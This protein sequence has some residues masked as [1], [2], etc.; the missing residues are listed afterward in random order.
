[1]YKKVMSKG[2]DEDEKKEV[3][4]LPEFKNR[5]DHVIFNKTLRQLTA[6][7]NLLRPKGFTK[8]MVQL[9]ARMQT[10]RKSRKAVMI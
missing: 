7:L 10:G 3:S 9:A 4:S 1:M 2:G 5:A 6:S 8:F